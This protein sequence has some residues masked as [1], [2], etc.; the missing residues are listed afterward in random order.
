MGCQPKLPEKVTL[1][2]SRADKILLEAQICGSWG[3]ENKREQVKALLKILNEKYE[4]NCNFEPQQGGKGEFYLF[5]IANENK[6]ILFSNNES[7]HKGAVIGKEL[8]VDKV[9]EV[10]NQLENYVR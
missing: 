6:Q 5:L 8:T 9:K 3:Y 10:Q 2:K 1:E 4:V 7:L